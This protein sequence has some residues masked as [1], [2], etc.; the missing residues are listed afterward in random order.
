MSELIDIFPLPLILAL[1]LLFFVL[2][3]V[4]ASF[5]T[6]VADRLERGESPWSGRSCC[7]LCGH[8][9]AAVDLIPVLSYLICGGKCRYCKARIPKRCIFTELLL[10][11]VFLLFFLR[12]GLSVSA[13]VY[14]ALACVLLGLSLVDID[15]YRI[16]NGFIVA[17]IVV[18]VL[19]IAAY[20]GASILGF[21]YVVATAAV[22]GHGLFV[23]ALGYGCLS[24][25]LD[26]LL[27]ALVLGGALL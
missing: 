16:P 2:G 10:G 25:V 23:G 20:L 26:G 24:M 18:W 17:G 14:S 11:L 22:Q 19:G 15:S 9:L 8:G 13:V 5:I 21:P 4:F 12:Y 1:A 3:A 6:C 7:D 27:G